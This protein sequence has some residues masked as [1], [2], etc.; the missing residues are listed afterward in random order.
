MTGGIPYENLYKSPATMRQRQ[1]EQLSTLCGIVEGISADTII[2]EQESQYLEQWLDEHTGQ[3]GALYSKLSAYLRHALTDRRITDDEKT[4]LLHHIA[5]LQGDGYY[6]L[7]TS[8]MQEFHG[9]LGGIAADG[10]INEAELR[11]RQDW[12]EKHE[13][14]AGHWPFTETDS[15]VC[16]VLANGT[17]DQGEHGRLLE[18]CRSFVDISGH[19]TLSAQSHSFGTTTT[20]IAAV[21]PEII[22][23][24]KSFCVTGASHKVPR[25]VIQEQITRLGGKISGVRHDLDYLIYCDAGQKCWA[26]ACYGRKVEQVMEYRIAGV[27]TTLIVAEAD[28]WDAL[29]DH[30]VEVR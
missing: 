25:K 24:G 27:A 9:I 4:D 14:L 8:H 2:N 19:K 30:G 20:G 17:I 28:Y 21:S 6:N 18:W 10:V 29:R 7:F 5:D 12:M 13:D 15:L 11:V 3:A 26:Y 23:P 1:D 22:F 16:A